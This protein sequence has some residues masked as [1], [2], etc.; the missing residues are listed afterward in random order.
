MSLHTSGELLLLVCFCS[1]GVHVQGLEIRHFRVCLLK[2]VIL[3]K[4]WRVSVHLHCN[5]SACVAII[6]V[7]WKDLKGNR[8]SAISVEAWAPTQVFLLNPIN[9]SCENSHPGRK[10]THLNVFSLLLA[11]FQTQLPSLHF[12]PIFSVF[13]VF[14]TLLYSWSFPILIRQRTTFLIPVFLKTLYCLWEPSLNSAIPL[15]LPMGPPLK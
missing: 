10:G 7:S 14:P 9:M 1:H 12:C 5:V 13:F 8:K 4:Y 11:F 15:L 2:C 3:L 6:S